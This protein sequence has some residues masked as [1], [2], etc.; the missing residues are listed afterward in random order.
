MKPNILNLNKHYK[1]VWD[2]K[3]IK[4]PKSVGM[5]EFLWHNIHC[6]YEHN[7]KTF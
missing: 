3:I 6:I 7:P 5:S 4:I 2:F 1:L